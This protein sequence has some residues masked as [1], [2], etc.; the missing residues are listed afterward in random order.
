MSDDVS[1]VELR[2]LV[3]IKHGFAFASEYFCDDPS[4]N[5]NKKV[6]DAANGLARFRSEKA[7]L[8]VAFY[9]A[10]SARVWEYHA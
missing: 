3:D 4:S 10:A 5:L 9:D 7:P 8:E 1:Y 2:D 6:V